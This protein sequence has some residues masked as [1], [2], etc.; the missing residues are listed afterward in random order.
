MQLLAKG[1]NTAMLDAGRRREAAT[2][3]LDGRDDI[4]H[5]T[6]GVCYDVVAYVRY[7]LGASI[8]P[9]LLVLTNGQEWQGRFNFT[10]GSLWMG[11]PIVR[12][13]AVGFERKQGSVFHAAIA[14]GETR[15]RG[16]NGHRL[17]PGWSEVVDLSALLAP[18]DSGWCEYDGTKIRV[19]LSAL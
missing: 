17:S 7:L 15:I 2:R 9:D 1:A 18:D 3:L 4:L 5:H 8:K 6:T 11:L 16:I 13:T 14:V 12:G 19:W 10:H